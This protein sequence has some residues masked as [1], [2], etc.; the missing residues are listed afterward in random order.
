MSII[1]DVSMLPADA[2]LHDGDMISLMPANLG[3]ICTG[4]P[5]AIVLELLVDRLDS[6]FGRLA[7]RE[8]G[9]WLIFIRGIWR[10]YLWNL[11][12]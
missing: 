9:L 4:D 12:G 5:V 3:D 1:L 11:W 8:G 2:I 10:S 7:G 6:Q